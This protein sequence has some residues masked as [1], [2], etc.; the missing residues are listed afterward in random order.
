MKKTAI[1][2]VS[3]LTCLLAGCAQP[4]SETASAP[5]E[6]QV[7]M[8]PINAMGIRMLIPAAGK[9]GMGDDGYYIVPDASDTTAV[10]QINLFT[11]TD[12][13]VENMDLVYA[14]FEGSIKEQDPEF[15]QEGFLEGRAYYYTDDKG[16]QRECTVFPIK[17]NS[18]MV[19]CL[20]MNMSM[21]PYFEKADFTSA[22]IPAAAQEPTPAPTPVPTPEPTP[23]PTLTAEKFSA[24]SE[25]MTLVEVQEL[26]G[27]EGSCE[28]SFDLMGNSSETWQFG[29]NIL[30]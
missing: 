8:K 20:A 12:K 30:R 25:N 6:E 24:I 1:A 9:A 15:T 10:S 7:E 18:M 28:Y 16:N 22:E 19:V 23:E 17:G 29:E 4:S 27:E 21:K 26:L 14:Y 11:L 2:I 5:M 3:I 13:D